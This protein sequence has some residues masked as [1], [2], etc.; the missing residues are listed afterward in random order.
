MSDTLDLRDFRPPA[1]PYV[2]LTW[3]PWPP[4]TI[5]IDYL[6]TENGF[7][8]FTEDGEPLVA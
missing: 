4:S 1:S 5:T 2:A 6:L 8:L 3:L 7:V